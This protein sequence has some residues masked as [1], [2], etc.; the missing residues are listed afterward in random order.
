MGRGVLAEVNGTFERSRRVE[1]AAAELARMRRLKPDYDD[2]ALVQRKISKAKQLQLIGALILV[3]GITGAVGYY[4]IM[5]KGG[6]GP[7][8]AT[9]APRVIPLSSRFNIPSQT[10]FDAAQELT[11]LP[12]FQD[13]RSF[14]VWPLPLE[15]KGRSQPFILE[16]K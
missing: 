5:K 2:M 14:G 7:L 9:Q 8:D 1:A 11:T 15:P 13:L 10:G 16:K 6:P 12:L 4:G 3:I